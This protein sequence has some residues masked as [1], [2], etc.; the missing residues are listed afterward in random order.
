MSDFLRV[1]VW[2][3]NAYVGMFAGDFTVLHGRSFE[4]VW[5]HQAAP[6]AALVLNLPVFSGCT[7]RTGRIAL[8]TGWGSTS[9]SGACTRSCK[10]SS[11]FSWFSDFDDG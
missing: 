4:E 1:I 8:S 3:K 5:R 11:T 10:V 6:E 2:K 9:S 7:L